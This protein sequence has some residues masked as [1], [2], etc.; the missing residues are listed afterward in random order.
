MNVLADGSAVYSGNQ[1]GQPCPWGH[2]AIWVREG[3]VW[4]CSALGECHLEFWGQFWAPQ[5]E[6]DIELVEEC[7]KKGHK[8]GEGSRGEGV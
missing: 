6:K 4:L 7:P 2:Q 3:I 5:Y 8:D 1:D